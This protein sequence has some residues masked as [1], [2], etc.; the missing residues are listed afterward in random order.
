MAETDWVKEL[1]SAVTVC[2]ADGIILSMNNRSIK[3]FEE[4]G[5]EALIGTNVLDCHP[6]PARSKLAAM[7]QSGVAN[8]YTIQKK[9]KKK[10]IHQSPWYHDGVYS[11]FVEISIEL[12]DPMQHFN[13][14]AQ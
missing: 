9:G 4:D 6:E 11:G 13:R 8:T 10:L 14:D 2:G 5:G 12:P 7:L 3:A 1:P